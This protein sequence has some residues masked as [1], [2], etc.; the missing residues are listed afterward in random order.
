[1]KLWH[2]SAPMVLLAWQ[3]APTTVARGS[4]GHIDVS[5]GYGAAE[6]EGEQFNCAGDLV[7]TWRI[8]V[9]S[10]GVQVDVGLR[11]DLYLSAFGGSISSG[12]EN[13]DGGDRYNGT[14]A[15]FQLRGELERVG[16]GLGLASV[17]GQ[18]LV[19]SAYGRLGRADKPHFRLDL[20]PPTP[21]LGATAWLRAGVGFNEAPGQAVGGVVGLGLMPYSYSDRLSPRPFAELHLRTASAFDLL[22]GGQV[23]FGADRT[24]WAAMLGIRYHAR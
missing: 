10:A 22:V 15:G 1:M 4:T 3:A 11:P 18:P 24:E 14:Y 13:S 7:G 9:R 19:P 8:P 6:Y 16:G 5:I 23:G 2:L 20:L 21:A 12:G 17:P